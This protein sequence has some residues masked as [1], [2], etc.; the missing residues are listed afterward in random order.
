MFESTLSS[1]NLPHNRMEGFSI[2]SG[3]D[4]YQMVNLKCVHFYSKS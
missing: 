2:I 4:D 3:I 1:L